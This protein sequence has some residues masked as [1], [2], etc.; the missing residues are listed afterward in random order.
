MNIVSIVSCFLIQISAVNIQ[1]IHR[2]ALLFFI[3]S[4]IPIT[5]ADLRTR[6]IADRYIL[7][8]GG[9]AVFALWSEQGFTVV[10]TVFASD[11][12]I[13]LVA[14]AFCALPFTILFFIRDDIGGADAKFAAVLGFF[15]GFESGTFILLLACISTLIAILIHRR[16]STRRG[17][18]EKSFRYPLIPAMCFFLTLYT[19]SLLIESF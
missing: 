11:I 6:Y 2:I 1:F 5:V 17:S 10:G 8:A 14:A 7:L 19:L 3:F 12:S 4:L 15:C 16:Y 9:L 13:R 18:A